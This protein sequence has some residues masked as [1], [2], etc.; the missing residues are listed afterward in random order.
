MIDIKEFELFLEQRGYSKTEEIII[1][2]NC[3]TRFFSKK[4]TK[5]TLEEFLFLLRKENEHFLYSTAHI[6]LHNLCEFG[7]LGKQ[8]HISGKHEYHWVPN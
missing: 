5:I 2:V 4:N 7:A 6:C 3:L 1:A 8:E